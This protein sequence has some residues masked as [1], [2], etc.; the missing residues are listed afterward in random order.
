M[1]FEVLTGTFDAEGSRNPQG[2]RKRSPTLG[3]GQ[4]SGTRV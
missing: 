1:L 3:F 2:S 4:T